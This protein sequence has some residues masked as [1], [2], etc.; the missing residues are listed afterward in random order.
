MCQRFKAF[1]YSKWDYSLRFKQLI[2]LTLKIGAEH[3]MVDPS[4]LISSDRAVAKNI[5]IMYSYIKSNLIK[6]LTKIN[7]F[8]VTCD[9]WNYKHRNDDYLTVTIQYVE[10]GKVISRVLQTKQSFGHSADQT[11]LET[12]KCLHEFGITKKKLF[13]YR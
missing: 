9:H 5:N 3:G 13:H 4:Q 2:G 11:S 8:G 1:W 12:F 6:I 7:T 10:D